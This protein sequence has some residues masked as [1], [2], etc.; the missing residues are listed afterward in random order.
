MILKKW[1]SSDGNEIKYMYKKRNVA[2]RPRFISRCEAYFKRGTRPLNPIRTIEN[3]YSCV[4]VQ[5]PDFLTFNDMPR[6]TPS[7]F[8]AISA[9]IEQ[10]HIV[11]AARKGLFSSWDIRLSYLDNLLD[12]PQSARFRIVLCGQ[13]ST[14]T[15]DAIATIYFLESTTLIS[16]FNVW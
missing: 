11:P 12:N 7:K 2:A 10:I 15:I 1:R 4:S 16:R 3:G 6:I 9:C 8:H 13:K 5:V 14:S